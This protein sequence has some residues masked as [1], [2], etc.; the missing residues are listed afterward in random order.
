MKGQG[1]VYRLPGRK[2]WMLDYWAPASDGRLIRVRESSETDDER[3]A[4]GKLRDKVAAVR[5]AKKRDEGVELPAHRRVTVAQLLDDYL[6][7]LALRERKGAKQEAYRLGPESPLRQALG[8]RKAREITRSVLVKYAERRRDEGRANAT[9]NRDLQGLRSAFLLAVKEGRLIRVPVFPGRLKERVRSGFFD[10][11]DLARLSAASPPW[12]SAMVQ[13][14]FATGW[15]LGELRGLRWDSIDLEERE[16]RLPDSKNDE[17][18]VIPI[19]GELVS[20]MEGL[21]VQ[22]GDSEFVFHVDGRPISK[23]RYRRAWAKAR[24][25]ARL[26]GRIFHDF[27]RTGARRLIN[28]GVSQAVAMKVTGHKTPSIFRR[29]QIVEKEDI[30]A[31]LEKV[32]QT[33]GAKVVGMPSS[34]ARQ[35]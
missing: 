23:K 25:A 6:R 20:V 18:R 26:E 33:A 24:K 27:R 29:Y 13:F 19:V 28:A 10:A 7:D 3:I 9:I 31:A 17:G 5:T 2:M 35:G 14:A 34:G 11:G 4:R 12:L 16:I 30:A 21:A 15:R 8:Y 1:R 32:A 22:R